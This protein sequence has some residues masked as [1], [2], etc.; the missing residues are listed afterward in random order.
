MA[1][2]ELFTDLLKAEREED[3][4][5]A[6]TVFGLEKFSD[7]NWL[8][9]GGIENNY[10]II[11]AQQADAIGALVEKVVNSIDAVLMREC[12]A[13]NL[14]P[15]SNLVPRSMVEA[16]EQFLNI[17]D[18][19]LAK[20]SAAQRTELAERNISTV[21]EQFAEESESIELF[22][23]LVAQNPALAEILG[24]GLKI[25]VPRPGDQPTPRFDGQRF[26]TFLDTRRR[27]PKRRVR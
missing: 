23:K 6:L 15:R 19:N 13:R 17:P 10:G 16:A 22:E 18:G 7:S 14:D 5:D 27:T 3:V 25:I 12:F 21:E 4:T 24:I 9:Y 20:W 26:P 1:Y 8:P 2:E 11:G